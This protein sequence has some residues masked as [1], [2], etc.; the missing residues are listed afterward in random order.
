MPVSRLQRH[1][2]INGR[3][4]AWKPGNPRSV[5]KTVAAIMLAV[6]L[7]L[8]SWIPAS[9]QNF[10]SRPAASAQ[11]RQFDTFILQAQSNLVN[12]QPAQALDVLTRATS[13][14]PNS[15]P[16][17]FWKGL[18]YDALGDPRKAVKEYAQSLRL[19]KTVGMDSAELRINLGHSLLKLGF[20]KEAVYDY[21][22]AIEI[23]PDSAPAYLYLGRAYLRQGQ[24]EAAL[25]AFRKSEELGLSNSSLPYLQALALSGLGQTADAKDE[26]APCLS[27]G[28]RERDPALFE[29]AASL[30]KALS[31]R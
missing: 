2:K 31:R 30:R 29:E 26:L 22:R 3:V 21:R 10:M 11:I 5:G 4:S 8:M 7:S 13:L 18:A 6:Q 17:Y 16:L 19:A 9:A 28:A 12:G 1:L 14:S 15:L 23:E 24:F 25:Q 27:D 20:V